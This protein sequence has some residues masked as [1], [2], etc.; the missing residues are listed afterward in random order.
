VK[1]KMANCPDCGVE[2]GQV[3]QDGCD[4]ERCSVCGSQAL[5]CEC[6]TAERS[7]HDKAFARWSGFWPG[8]LESDS[9]GIDLNEFYRR[10][11]NKVLFVKPGLPHVVHIG[12]GPAEYVF[13]D[14]SKNAWVVHQKD[15]PELDSTA[16][17]DAAAEQLPEA[18]RAALEG[19]DMWLNEVF[20]S[21]SE[22]GDE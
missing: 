17:A 12:S 19:G 7:W 11:L 16:N 4:V 2:P 6:S 10:R 9:M 14:L 20:D 15:D 3:H 22:T 8:S 18:Q 1:E 13:L 21:T 5:G